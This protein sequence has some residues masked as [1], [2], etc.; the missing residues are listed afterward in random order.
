M[1][2]FGAPLGIS[3]LLEVGLLD[4]KASGQRKL[5]GRRLNIGVRLV[6]GHFG[7]IGD[8]CRVRRGRHLS[9]AIQRPLLRF[10]KS[11]DGPGVLDAAEI[12]IKYDILAC[13]SIKPHPCSRVPLDAAASNAAFPSARFIPAELAEREKPRRGVR[14]SS[15]F[16]SGMAVAAAYP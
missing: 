9:D 10:R 16:L 1:I 14:S 15:S 13:A 3:V 6:E 5:L 8:V 12:G 11:L 4:I 2:T 7:C